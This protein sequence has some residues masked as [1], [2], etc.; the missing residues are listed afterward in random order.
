[1][2]G[3]FDKGGVA[4]HEDRIFKLLVISHQKLKHRVGNSSVNTHSL[5][6]KSMAHF[7]TTSILLFVVLFSF[8]RRLFQLKMVIDGAASAT[9]IQRLLG[10]VDD[11]SP[12]IL[13]DEK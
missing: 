4:L 2:V 12:V 5:K 9:F 7:V 10:F 11:Y 1:M 6:K 3:S 13:D 8:I